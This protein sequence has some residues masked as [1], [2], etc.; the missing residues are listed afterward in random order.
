MKRTIPFHVGLYCLV[1]L[2][3]W[4]GCAPPARAQGSFSVTSDGLRIWF[5]TYGTGVPI[6]LIPGGPGGSCGRFRQTHMLLRSLGKIVLMDNRGRGLSDNPGN[7]PGSFTLDKDVLDVEAVRHALGAEK[8]IVF[9]HSYG[10]M[11]AMAYAARHPERTI[12]LITSGGVHGAKAFQERNIDAIKQH[13]KTHAPLRW[14]RILALRKTGVRASEDELAELFGIDNEFFY[15]YDQSNEQRTFSQFDY[16]SQP[17]SKQW[18]PEVYRQMVGD[19]P[20]WTL[21]GSLAGVELLPELNN[22]TGPALIMGGRYDRVCPPINQLEISAAL[23]NARLVIFDHSGHNPHYEEPLRFLD[24]VTDFLQLVL[25]EHAKET[26][27][28]P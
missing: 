22:F 28:Q 1:G 7:K 16:R 18:N 24:V 9:G 23:S 6:I 25:A 15:F 12:A 13:I 20:D 21:T 14:Q 11:V 2:T 4:A 19:D 17:R 8:V 26:A 10:S 27:S 3:A 5:E